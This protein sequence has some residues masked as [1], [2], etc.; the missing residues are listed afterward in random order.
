[1]VFPII[2][3]S[4]TKSNAFLTILGFS[5]FQ[6]TFLESGS[7][8]GPMNILVPID[9]FTLSGKRSSFRF[10]TVS[11]YGYGFRTGLIGSTRLS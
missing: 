9:A 2:T 10:R 8:T 5:L 11:L 4:I 1:M 3:T 7:F 6:S